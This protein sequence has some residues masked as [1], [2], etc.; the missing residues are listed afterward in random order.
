MP[1]WMVKMLSDGRIPFV[2]AST[3]ATVTT[4]REIYH[5][6]KPWLVILFVSSITLLSLS[7]AGL[8][9]RFLTRGPDVF[10]PF[11]GLTYG[12]RYLALPPTGSFLDG[13][14]RSKILRRVD[15][16]LGDAKPNHIVGE[17]AFA[18][19]VAVGPLQR[20]RL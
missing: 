2:G 11:G 8:A 19:S 13:T 9:V 5:A 6:D 12:S 17:I 14:A 10:D 16:R 1:D 18:S 3:T 4:Y 20:D 7:L 15:V